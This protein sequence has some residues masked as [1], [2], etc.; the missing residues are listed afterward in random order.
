LAND[1]VPG[2]IV[3]SQ[4]YEDP[5]S[6]RGIHNYEAQTT[7]LAKGSGERIVKEVLHLLKSLA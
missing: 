1:Q 4:A 6:K 3:T 2:Y 7:A 5:P